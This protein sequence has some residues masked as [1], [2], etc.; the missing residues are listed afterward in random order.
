MHTSGMQIVGDSLRRQMYFAFNLAYRG[1]NSSRAPRDRVRR[2]AE[3]FARIQWTALS[4]LV[5]AELVALFYVYKM[6]QNLPMLLPFAVLVICSLALAAYDEWTFY[7]LAAKP[8]RVA[9]EIKSLSQ[10]S[11]A[12][13]RLYLR[14]PPP[15][16]TWL[17]TRPKL[18]PETTF[19]FAGNNLD[20]LVFRPLVCFRWAWLVML[21]GFFISI[22]YCLQVMD[23]SKT[24]SAV[25]LLILS[26]SYSLYPVTQDAWRR[27]FS[28]K[29]LLGVLE[30]TYPEAA[31]ESHINQQ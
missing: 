21:G 9:A 31:V 24:V 29:L 16:R 7:W 3:K 27:Y 30:E 13:E 14:I 1:S 5:L 22:Q 12:A 10:E 15:L 26:I 25:L 23:P 20:W 8:R 19:I 28:I 2:R 6:P 11:G 4:T 18:S 17:Y